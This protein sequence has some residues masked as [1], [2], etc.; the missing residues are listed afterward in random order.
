MAQPK[1]PEKLQHISVLPGTHKKV[2]QLSKK[3]NIAIWA[4]YALA[5][6]GLALDKD[7]A[8]KLAA[9]TPAQSGSP[10]RKKAV[11]KK[12]PAKKPIAKKKVPEK[13]PAAK[14][15]AVKKKIAK[16]KAK[17]RKKS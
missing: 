2:Q 8:V 10:V 16:T 15:N 7:A 14:K 5:V 12:K 3:H 11:A 6:K 13:K 4:L 17:L 1:A 9:K